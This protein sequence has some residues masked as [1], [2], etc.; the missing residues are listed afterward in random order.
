MSANARAA[1][2]EALIEA[3]ATELKLPTVK[4]R[5][6]ALAA[7][8]TRAQQT[9]VAYLA[10]LLDAEHHERAERRERRRLIDARF[11]IVKRLEDFR[12][13]DNPNIPQATIAA[14][15]EGSWIDDRESVIFI[16]ESG[17]G[18]TMLA[19]ALAVCACHQGRRVRFTTLAGL[20]NELQEADSRRELARVVG[21]YART[22]LVCLDELGYLALPEGAAELVFQVISERNERGA[23]IVTT[24]LPFGEW[25]KVFPDPRLA[26]AVVD[27]LTH[28]AHIIETGSESWRFRHGLARQH[29]TR[30]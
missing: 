2:L 11:P 14:L 15:A 17:T 10:A 22:E 12:F 23:L 5:F 16:G 4:R 19:T 7:E 27:R 28:K 6:R 1:A 13:Q 18:K 20:A 21:R 9:P 8:A 3:H 26:K 29:K 24:N 30:G 25:T